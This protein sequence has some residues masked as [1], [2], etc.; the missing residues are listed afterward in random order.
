MNNKYVKSLLL[1][2]VCTAGVLVLAEEESPLQRSVNTT[3][4][5]FSV[6]KQHQEAAANS[7]IKKGNEC[8]VAGNYKEA[9]RNYA[10]AVYIFESLKPTSA[11]FAE[12]QDKARELIAKS[13]YYLA[14][15]TA[16]KAHEE[17]NY[18][19]LENAIALAKKPLPSILP[20]AKK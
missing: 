6:D 10:Q 15:E 18:S 1:T 5:A 20:A 13:Y 3:V 14:Q 19:E 11:H 8:F 16:L 9:A 7:F 12:E 2:A 17:A 4:D